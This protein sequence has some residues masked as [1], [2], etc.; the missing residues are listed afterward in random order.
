MSARRVSVRRQPS[1][2]GLARVSQGIRGWDVCVD[3][4]VVVC[5]RPNYPSVGAR[6]RRETCGWYFYVCGGGHLG[7]PTRNT[8]GEIGRSAED[9]K[10][11]AVA[12]VR[13]ALVAHAARPKGGAG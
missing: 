4:K 6:W 9:V 1:E 10:A 12:F 13:A 7:I 5:V 8:C 3:R 11:E 2:T